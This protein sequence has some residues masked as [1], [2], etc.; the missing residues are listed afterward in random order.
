MAAVLFFAALGGGALSASKIGHADCGGIASGSACLAKA[1]CMWCVSSRGEEC[2]TALAHGASRQWRC[3]NSSLPM[4]EG[5]TD[6]TIALHNGVQMPVVALG[7]GGYD[8]ETAAAAVRIA[9]ASGMSHW[10]LVPPALI[11]SYKPDSCSPALISSDKS[12]ESSRRRSQSYP[13]GLRLLQSARCG[14]G[15]G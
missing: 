7:T 1:G 3:T 9:L 6:R 15:S 10:T 5:P 4:P 8:N 12:D 11:S 14:G 13:H 2:S